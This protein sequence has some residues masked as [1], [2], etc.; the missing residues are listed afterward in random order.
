M[1][2]YEK[3]LVKTGSRDIGGWAI[4]SLSKVYETEDFIGVIH[5]VFN[6]IRA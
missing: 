4:E 3:I 5:S 2:Q 1:T 6:L